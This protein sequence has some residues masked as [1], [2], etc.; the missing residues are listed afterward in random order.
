MRA[1]FAGLVLIGLTAPAPAGEKVDP[2]LLVG[3]WELQSGAGGKL[4]GGL[5]VAYTAD[6]KMTG[7]V[8]VGTETLKVEGTYTVAGD[9]VR[10]KILDGG[11]QVRS[12][13]TVS[14]LTATEMVASDDGRP[15]ETYRRVA[16]KK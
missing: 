6:G 1:L 4:D 8:R 7:E 3:T 2:K 16:A 5:T 15:A 10:L 12:V 11:K 9:Q 14:K 13:V